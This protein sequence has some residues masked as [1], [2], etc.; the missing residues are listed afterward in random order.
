M[1]ALIA[2]EIVSLLFLILFSVVYFTKK[3]ANTNEIKNYSLFLVIGILGFLIELSL[4]F[5]TFLKGVPFLLS[6]ES[7]A[8]IYVIHYLVFN[9]LLMRYVLMKIIDSSDMS[10]MKKNKY[11]NLTTV[12][13]II[14]GIISSIVL[15]SLK[16]NIHTEGGYYYGLGQ[17]TNFIFGFSVLTSLITIFWGIIRYNKLSKKEKVLIVSIISLYIINGIIRYFFPFFTINNTILSFIIAIMFFT[18]ENP[19]IKLISELERA[20]AAKDSF[21]SSMSHQIKTPLNIIVGLSEKTDLSD[22]N[23]KSNINDINKEAKILSE[24][25]GNIIDMNAINDDDLTINSVKYY[26]REDF[27]D[28]IFDYKRRIEDNGVKFEYVFSD[29]IPKVLIGDEEKIAMCIS[30]ILSNSWKY[31]K[32]GE[33]VL[34]FGWIVDSSSL[35]I[36]IYDTGEGIDNVDELFKNFSRKT[37]E[38]NSVTPG[39]G[40]GLVLCKKV[41]DSM[42]GLLIINSEK[43]TGTEIEMIIPQLISD[44]SKKVINNSKPED[45]EIEVLSDEED[46]ISTDTLVSNVDSSQILVVDDN[47]LNLKVARRLLESLEYVVDESESGF[48]AIDKIKNHNNYKCIFMD[49]MMPEMDGV[50]AMKKIKQIDSSINVIALTADSAVGSKEK[51][52]SEGFDDYIAKPVSKVELQRTLKNIV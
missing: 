35:S 14:Y 32:K 38:F 17:R 50:A 47:K 16:S 52:L 22:E 6:S 20:N 1:I 11:N 8:K 41:I 28:I 44:D 5:S 19:D 34:K 40:L 23:L 36:N 45:S 15:V 31:T 13:L 9:I 43:N 29:D 12:I 33:I 30:R 27:N 24:L 4:N 21:I 46:E 3:R 37:D 7:I 48:N 51:Y 42:N 18:I 39:V 25:L 26:V 2:V 10:L 49:I